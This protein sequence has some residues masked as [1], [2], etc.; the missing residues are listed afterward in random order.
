[1]T[2]FRSLL[3]RMAAL[4]SRLARTPR[5]LGRWLLPL[6]ALAAAALA[7]YGYWHSPA[8]DE[9]D[10]RARF[11][12]EDPQAQRLLRQAIEALQLRG[13]IQ[14]KVRQRA[15][16]FGFSLLGWGTYLQADPSRMLS[17]WEMQLESEGD[18]VT[19]LQVCDGNTLW[20]YQRGLESSRLTR[21]DV[22]AVRSAWQAGRGTAE[23]GGL[24][25]P[26]LGGL[27]HWLDTLRRNFNFHRV[28]RDWLGNV[29]VAV[30][31]GTWTPAALQQLL[32]RQK[33]RLQQGG[34][35]DWEQLPPQLPDRVDLYLGEDDLFP[36]RVVY[37]RGSDVDA[38]PLAVVELFEVRFNAPI[39][40]ERFV[41]APGQRTAVDETAQL[42]QQLLGKRR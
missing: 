28:D 18:V 16:A 13:S 26:P 3:A 24:A 8:A 1:M 11:Q 27:A 34:I 12:I 30:L 4:A 22:A 10:E 21:V 42:I 20:T 33:Q 35:P 40:P 7:G 14:A 9:A 17:R 31:R 25:A 5:R 29:P 39:D 41:Y 19:W 37:W 38:P 32:P 36:Y 23:A 6:A 2:E 15:E